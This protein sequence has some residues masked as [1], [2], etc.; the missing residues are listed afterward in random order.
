V[1]F[2]IPPSP[3]H[4]R[5]RPRQLPAHDQG[6]EAAHDE[7][8]QAQ[9]EELMGDCPV[10]GGEKVRQDEAELEVLG[11]GAIVPGRR[12]AH[13]RG[14]LSARRLREV[15]P[16]LATFGATRPAPRPKP[17]ASSRPDAHRATRD[18]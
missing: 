12:D 8:E 16:R 15:D 11:V 5:P 9:E 2:R 13:A 7:H 4:R 18:A 14:A 3:G 17:L 6:E 10:V 1:S